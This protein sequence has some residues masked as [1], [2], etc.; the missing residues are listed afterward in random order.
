MG[1]VQ[2][3]EFVSTCVVDDAGRKANLASTLLRG[4][5][6]VEQLPDRDARLAIV[7]SGPSVQ[8]HLEEIRAW[9]GEVW[10]VNGAYRFLLGK[11][12]VP[13]GFVGMDPLPGL[14][15]Y[16]EITDPRT[17]FYMCSIC[18]PSVF[19]NLKDRK[20]LL[21]HPDGE[22]VDYPPDQWRI[23]GGTTVVTRAPYLALLQGWRDI[24]LFGVDSSFAKGERY[25]YRHGT[26]ECDSDA[27]TFWVETNG[28]GP[29]E[30]ELC[31]MKQV[32]Q[33]YALHQKFSGK[34]TFRCG[35]LLAAFMRAPAIDDSNF[36]LVQDEADAA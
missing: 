17:T 16:V 4:L 35:G 5:P 24:T 29:F 34:L 15:P 31:L 33:L 14:A 22:G 1:K 10:A 23:G 7:A 21:W 3:R 8:D 9:D 11:G 19:D 28:E 20:V 25:S 6:M 18:D 30:T 32:S 2:L 26:F 27:P 13:Q 12:I 36:E